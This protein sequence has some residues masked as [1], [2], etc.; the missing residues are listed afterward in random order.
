M[1]ALVYIPPLTPCKADSNSNSKEYQIGAIRTVAQP[2]R[3][4]HHVYGIF[5][6]PENYKYDHLYSAKLSIQGL[7]TDF[8]AGSS[9]DGDLDSPL[10]KPGHY[11]KR[12]HLSTRTALWYLFTGRFGDL[13]MSCHWW[14]VLADRGWRPTV[15]AQ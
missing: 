9:E 11:I 15:Q 13:Q 3:G 10:A 12:V 1:T 7:A 14:L 8:I 6:I 2:W 5:M 4:P